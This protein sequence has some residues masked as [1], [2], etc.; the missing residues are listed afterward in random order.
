MDPAQLKHIEGAALFYPCCG[1]DFDTP[2]KLFASAV[3]AFYFVDVHTPRRL[4]DPL[5]GL[6]RLHRKGSTV[7]QRFRHQE[8]GNEFDL[9]R[10]QCRGEEAF[11]K[12][13]K[14]GVFFHRGDTLTPCQDTR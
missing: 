9:Y 12:I 10:W 5:P 4:A 14:I 2:I 1:R 13:Q 6:E 11:E 8:S 3:E 7:G